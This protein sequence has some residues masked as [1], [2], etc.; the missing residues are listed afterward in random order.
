MLYWEAENPA[1]GEV[2]YL[3]V[4]SYHLQNPNLYSKEGLEEAKRLLAKF[5]KGQANPQQIRL[6]SKDKVDS[7]KR[8]WKIKASAAS[9]GA[10]EH[11]IQWTMTAADVVAGG[12]TNYCENVRNWLQSILVTL[13]ATGNLQLS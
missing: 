9:R 2:H 8:Q 10:H 13:I 1:L 3:M 5:V 12:D 11:P 6:R 7:G 4:L